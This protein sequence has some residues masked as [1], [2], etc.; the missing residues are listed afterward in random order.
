MPS[1]RSSELLRNRS[2]RAN[3]TQ[4]C[5]QQHGLEHQHRPD[6]LLRLVPERQTQLHHRDQRLPQRLEAV[7]RVTPVEG[8]PPSV[9]VVPADLKIVSSV[10]RD[11]GHQLQVAAE[12]RRDEDIDHAGASE[13]T[14]Q[15]A[16]QAGAEYTTLRP[17][18]SSEPLQRPR[19]AETATIS[20]FSTVLS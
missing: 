14:K 20:A 3:T 18:R 6:E 13:E 17:E 12:E 10:I 16:G 4:T 1:Q 19:P 8:Q 9:G 11:L 7:G 5:R 15:Q 2:V